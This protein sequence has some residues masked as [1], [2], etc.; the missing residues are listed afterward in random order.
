MFTHTG[1]RSLWPVILFRPLL[2]LG[3]TRFGRRYGSARLP[4][5]DLNLRG[6][7]RDSYPSVRTVRRKSAAIL[8][9]Q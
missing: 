8:H 5:Q 2:F 7:G 4:G 9:A 3:V 1:V 6:E